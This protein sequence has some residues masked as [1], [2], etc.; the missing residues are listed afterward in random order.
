MESGA[1]QTDYINYKT[2]QGEI[3]ESFNSLNGRY[4]RLVGA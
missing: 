1:A 3:N 4:A 2:L